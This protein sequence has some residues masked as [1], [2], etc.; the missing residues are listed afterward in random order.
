MTNLTRYNGNF[1]D[2]ADG[3][4]NFNAQ[5]SKSFQGVSGID[6]SV[7]CFV[8]VFPSL[9]GETI[10]EIDT[11][12]PDDFKISKQGSTIVIEQKQS[13]GSTI[14]NGVVMGGTSFGNVVQTNV[15]GNVTIINGRVYINGV[16]QTASQSSKPNRPSRI[17]LYLQPGLDVEAD[18]NGSSVLASKVMFNDADIRVSGV[19]TVGIAAK[20]LSLRLSGQGENYVVLKGGDLDVNVSGQGKVRVKGEF[21]RCSASVSGMGSVSTEGS[22]LGDYRANVSGMGSINHNGL[23][24]GRVKKSVS[25]MGSISVG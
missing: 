20:S 2:F 12:D 22:C 21:K 8:G 25:G 7:S 9:N 1:I 5:H 17:R 19:A 15:S 6:L 14:I 4:F 24:A 3:E 11:D 23:V 10:V 18:L 16:E 13:S